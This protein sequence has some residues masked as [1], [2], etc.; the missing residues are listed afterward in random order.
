[1]RPN[2]IREAVEAV[3]DI[4]RRAVDVGSAPGTLHVSAMYAVPLF[5][6]THIPSAALPYCVVQLKD[7]DWKMPAAQGAVL[8]NVNLVVSIICDEKTEDRALDLIYMIL[9]HISKADALKD[10]WRH[11]TRPFIIKIEASQIQVHDKMF[12]IPVTVMIQLQMDTVGRA[13]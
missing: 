1:M 11:D 8:A 9:S 13:M 2:P 12:A 4:A 7:V 6:S 5:D 3:L 10:V